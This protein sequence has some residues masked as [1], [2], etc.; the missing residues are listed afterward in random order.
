MNKPCTGLG[1]NLHTNPRP[2]P[3]R[4]PDDAAPEPLHPPTQQCLCCEFYMNHLCNRSDGTD[5]ART[6][7]QL[8]RT[9][10]S[11]GQQRSATLRSSPTSLRYGPMGRRN[12]GNFI[13][14]SELDIRVYI[15]NLTSTCPLP[16]SIHIKSIGAGQTECSLH[17]RCPC[18]IA[19]AAVQRSESELPKHQEQ[20]PY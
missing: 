4:R 13:A 17:Q 11:L 15:E 5:G 9:P 3:S 1:C 18:T 6:S 2:T 20:R 19:A 12:L 8:D 14:G 16:I 7:T 10:D